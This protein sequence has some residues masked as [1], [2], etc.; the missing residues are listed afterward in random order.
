MV[1]SFW[2][3]LGFLSFKDLNN[4]G[5]ACALFFDFIGFFGFFV[6][7]GFLVVLGFLDGFLGFLVGL[8]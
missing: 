6:V 7:D 4:F 8:F 5:F 1:V 3:F 2:V